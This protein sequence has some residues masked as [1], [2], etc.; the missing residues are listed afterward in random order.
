M[1]VKQHRLKFVPIVVFEWYGYENNHGTN[2]KK[3]Q[4]SHTKH[5]QKNKMQQ[6]KKMNSH[7]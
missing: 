7:Y 2:E 6:Q 1:P 4:N 3:K 5:D